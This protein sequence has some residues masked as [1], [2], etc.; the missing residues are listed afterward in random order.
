MLLTLGGLCVG[1]AVFLRSLPAVDHMDF[2]RLKSAARA[3]I[4]DKLEDPNT[5]VSWTPLD[6]V[7]RNFLYAIVMSEDAN[8]FEHEGIDVDALLNSIAANLKTHR[9]EYGASTISQQVT[10]NLFLKNDKTLVRKIK[11]FILTER[12]ERHFSK[13]EILEIYLNVAEF[14]PDLF[15]VG[16]A[17]RH[18]FGKTPAEIN[19]AEGAFIALMLPSPRK[20]HFA[21]LENQNLSLARRRKIRRVLGDMLANDLISAGQYQKY[22]H[23]DFFKSR[24][25]S[26][27]PR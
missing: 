15:G 22:A 24:A 26:R 5:R 3:R 1:A 11:E 2:A 12:L 7:H 9:Y 17:A 13:N 8:Y 6:Q 27:H 16:A 18:Y 10:K 20:N 21:I 4:H 23:Y 14:G 25:T 19:P